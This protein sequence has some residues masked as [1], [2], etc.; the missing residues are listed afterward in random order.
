MRKFGYVRVCTSK[1][2]LEAQVKALKRFGCSE[3][4]YDYTK[5]NMTTSPILED[6]LKVLQSGDTLIVAR[7]NFLSNSNSKQAE[8]IKGLKGVGVDFISLR[9]L[10]NTKNP[11]GMLP[12]SLLGNN[13]SDEFTLRYQINERE[14]KRIDTFEKSDRA[15]SIK[16]EKYKQYMRNL[17]Q[18]EN[19]WLPFV[20]SLRP[21]ISWS[22]II[23][24][25][26]SHLSK[27]QA[28][29]IPQLLKAVRAYIADGRLSAIVLDKAWPKKID[30]SLFKKITE[31]KNIDVNS[32]PE[33]ICSYLKKMEITTPAGASEWY[34]EVIVKLLHAIYS[35]NRR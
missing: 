32:S 11:R 19:E 8:I 1:I 34:P 5:E 15:L 18:K 33:T 14:K 3:I 13:H 35:K 23:V 29:S 17:E 21:Y 24:I 25:I 27:H 12:I 20:K 22:R 7:T 28:W 26:N 10:I 30:R 9:N 4:I 6:L 16:V 2:S 31:V